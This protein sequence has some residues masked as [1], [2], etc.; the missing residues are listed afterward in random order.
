MKLQNIFRFAL[1]T[2]ILSLL[3]HTSLFSQFPHYKVTFIP[4]FRGTDINDSTEIVG[5]P[6]W[7]GEHWGGWYEVEK[8]DSYTIAISL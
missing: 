5:T 7:G 3:I 2:I 8:W 6:Y 1:A 4:N